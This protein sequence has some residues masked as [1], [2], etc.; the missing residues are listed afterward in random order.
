MLML[1]AGAVALAFLYRVETAPST[2]WGLLRW[3]E[4]AMEL[5]SDPAISLSVAVGF[6]LLAT[7]LLVYIN[8]HY[9]ILRSISLLFAGLFL[10]ME[11][12]QPM[13]CV[14]MNAGLLLAVV[15]L[16]A[17]VPLYAT[18]QQPGH[19]RQLFL[20]FCIV[21]AGALVEIACAA[22][23]LALLMGC[24]QMR[25]TTPRSAL[26]ALLGVA[27]PWWIAWGLG[28]LNVAD[29]QW[30][31][32]VGPLALLD[33]GE[34]AQVL[35]YAVA[36]FLLGTGFGLFNLLKIYSYNART[37]AYNGFV[38]VLAAMTVLLMLCDYT[39]LVVYLPLLNVC[40][41]IQMGHFFIINNRRRSYIPILCIV[42]LYA[43]LYA[44]AVAF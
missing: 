5:L 27:T 32:F 42:A 14:A 13:L 37:R 7:L 16:L 43:A 28:W 30:P 15:M 22:Y 17:V 40:T 10:V 24:F 11:A 8:K 39:R 19:T 31:E 38:V 35:V 3:P 41:A 9:N 6:N 36:T 33:G 1:S 21:S 2:G 4:R 20:S 29:L 34:V 26:A 44:V 12:A 23:L 18:F 25:C